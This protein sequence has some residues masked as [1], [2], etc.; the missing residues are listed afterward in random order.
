[1]LDLNES[2]SIDW[3]KG[4]NGA[5]RRWRE[6]LDMNKPGEAFSIRQ[7]VGRPILVKIKHRSY[8]G[9]LYEEVDSVSKA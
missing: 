1:M 8:Q 5:L 9:E 4:R 6:A 7:M 3:G 2:G